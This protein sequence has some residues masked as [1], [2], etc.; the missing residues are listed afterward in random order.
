ME[1]FKLKDKHKDSSRVRIEE[2][3]TYE[4][5]NKSRDRCYFHA[6]SSI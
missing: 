5:R 3:A 2:A 1:K 6:S 4:L